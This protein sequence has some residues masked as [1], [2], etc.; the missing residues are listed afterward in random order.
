MALTARQRACYQDLVDIYAL[1]MATSPTTGRR[2]AKT[3]TLIASAVRCHF[4][5]RQSVE[6]PSPMG[7]VETDNMFSLDEIHF[8]H[9]VVVDSDYI[10]VNRSLARDGS[11]SQNYGRYWIVR[12]QPQS[13]PS[14]GG[15]R[16]NLRIVQALQVKRPPAGVPYPLP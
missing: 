15:R 13:V 3:Y 10:L 16:A 11:R 14:H 1:T 6:G 5:L 8:E 12:G 2:T 7:R 9:S 4:K